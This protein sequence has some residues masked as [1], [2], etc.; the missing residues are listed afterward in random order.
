MEL[1]K[2]MLLTVVLMALYVVFDSIASPFYNPSLGYLGSNGAVHDQVF[3]LS[4]VRLGIAPW[5]SS[6]VFVEFFSLI[7]PNLRKM[8]HEFDGNRAKLNRCAVWLGFAFLF[9]HA[10]MLSYSLQISGFGFFANTITLVSGSCV[11][12]YFASTISKHGFGNGFIA[13][14]LVGLVEMILY[15]RHVLQKRV[16]IAD[17]TSFGGG[18]IIVLLVI[19]L[20]IF[21]I[22]KVKIAAESIE[23]EDSFSFELPSFPSSIKALS[24]SG[25]IFALTFL[26]E[27]SGFNVLS[28]NMISVPA[29][30]V[31]SVVLMPFFHPKI[32]LNDGLPQKHTLPHSEKIKIK[33]QFFLSLLALIV[34]AIY[35]YSDLKITENLPFVELIS[36]LFVIMILKDYVYEFIFRRTNRN[37]RVDRSFDQIYAAQW[38]A[39]LL[40]DKGYATHLQSFYTRSLFMVFLPVVKIRV[41]RSKDPLSFKK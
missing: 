7:L 39:Q 8:R 34:I 31:L 19:G 36:V 3:T 17:I 21:T 28:L 14:M 1:F 24:I 2:K 26:L 10:C 41:L 29:V 13:M 37:V 35:S 15:Q 6:F 11:I 40:R 22:R 16:P 9:I 30:I 5:L 32:A 38:Y 4:I 23:T 25:F 18:V 27:A 12:F 20:I 33:N